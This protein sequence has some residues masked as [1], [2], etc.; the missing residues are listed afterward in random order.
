MSRLANQEAFP[1]PAGVN[2]DR[3]EG[4]TLRQHYAG[5]AMQAVVSNERIARVAS[6]IAKGENLSVEDMF[7][8]MAV[9]Y[10]DAL[11]TELEKTPS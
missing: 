1:V 8:K 3:R 7:A 4:M 6:P 2:H 11:I 10:A 9:A 5:L